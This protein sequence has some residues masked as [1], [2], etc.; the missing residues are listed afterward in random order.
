[1]IDSSFKFAGIAGAM[2]LAISASVVA[3]DAVQWRVE[4][5]G[6][7]HWYAVVDDEPLAW[8]DARDLGEALGG[9][10]TCLES[11]EEQSWVF[12]FVNQRSF[13]LGLFQDPDTGG[14]DEN[15]QWLSGAPFSYD[16]WADGEPN[17]S[18]GAIEN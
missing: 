8:I 4:D 16:N 15:W 2:A 18:T 5:G 10:M 6:N 17:D 12:D 13:W 3:Q 9:G 7:G 1:M 14:P 11:P